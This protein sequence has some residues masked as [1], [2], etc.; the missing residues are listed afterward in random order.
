MHERLLG[1]PDWIDSDRFDL[2][3]SAPAGTSESTMLTMLQTLLADRFKLVLRREAREMAVYSL[4]IA[5][6][7]GRI[8]KALLPVDCNASRTESKAVVGKGGTRPLARG[9]SLVSPGLACRRISL[10]A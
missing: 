10:E 8:D 3:A 4:V 9:C 1:G 2:L 6:N 5:R 7:D